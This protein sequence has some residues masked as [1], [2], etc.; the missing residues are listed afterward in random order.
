MVAQSTGVFGHFNLDTNDECEL[1]AT[2][3]YLYLRNEKDSARYKNGI[4]VLSDAQ[5]R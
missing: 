1:L 5:F 3:L 2:A 4:K